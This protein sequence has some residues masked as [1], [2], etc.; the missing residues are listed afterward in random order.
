MNRIVNALVML[1]S[2]VLPCVRAQADWHAGRN[3]EKE[4]A[5]VKVRLTELGVSADALK[6]R[7]EIKNE[8]GHDIWL[9]ESIP[10]RSEFEVYFAED[11]ETL[12]IRRR[13]DVHTGIGWPIRPIG[14]YGCLLPGQSRIESLQF[15]L[16]VQSAQTFYGRE[17]VGRDFVYAGKLALELGFY[18][19]DVSNMVLEMLDK[20]ERTHDPG[21]L[22][23]VLGGS[24][25]FT[26]SNERI[27][28]RDQTVNLSWNDRSVKPEQVLCV[29][30]E[31]V[32]I[33]YASSRLMLGT[34]TSP[35]PKPPDLGNCTRA[36][37]TYEP[38]ML[39]YFFPSV[40]QQSLLMSSEER[41]YLQRQKAIVVE[42]AQQIQGLSN[43][44]RHAQS[45]G[46]VA[47]GSTAHV[48][49]YQDDK[50]L[51]SFTLYGDHGFVMEDGQQF[52]SYTWARIE[53][54]R[55]FAGP[56]QPFEV[57]ADC[58]ANLKNL[59]FRM[60]L[61]YRA[62][63]AGQGGSSPAPK[64]PA[65]AE[66]CDGVV[67]AYEKKA[68]SRAQ[69]MKPFK[70]PAAAQGKSHYA[71]NPNCLYGSPA[72][73]V[74]LFETKAGWNQHGGPELFTF[75]NHDPKGGLVLLNDGTVKFIRTE[76]ELKQLR[77]K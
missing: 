27:R 1:L 9:C 41:E 18:D 67:L 3:M 50:V 17:P 34:E 72:D 24:L 6:L 7:Y 51:A 77:W 5:G 69:V 58:A 2:C 33:P 20:A 75:D 19:S 70:C 65:P 32:N 25:M 47:T 44:I 66:W 14:T 56:A 57:R 48:V 73:M 4:V 36:T 39:E 60:R 29:L 15:R 43:E 26:L 68:V 49:C 40:G 10:H 71:M 31:D 37:V 21:G 12:T 35:F 64:Y 22:L 38:S 16:P 42:N 28:D 8:S 30:A 54:P 59:W 53:S 13:L 62:E 76:E 45:G 63:I 55:A 74:L 52:F 23:A 61:C 11:N 46:I